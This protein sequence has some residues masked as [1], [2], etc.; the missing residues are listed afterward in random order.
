MCLIE[1]IF[2]RKVLRRRLWLARARALGLAIFRESVGLKNKVRRESSVIKLIISNES[3]ARPWLGENFT[4]CCT[5]LQI[6]L[7]LNNMR[8]CIS[9]APSATAHIRPA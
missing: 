6:M 2:D 3:A 9:T 7:T 8:F 5:K 4:A 1:I